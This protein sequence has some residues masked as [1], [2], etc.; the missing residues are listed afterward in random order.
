[1]CSNEQA[2]VRSD[3]VNRGVDMREELAAFEVDKPGPIKH[4]AVV[5]ERGPDMVPE[6]AAAEDAFGSFRHVEQDHESAA[7]DEYVVPI[8][9][10]DRPAQVDEA[11]PLEVQPPRAAVVKKIQLEISWRPY[12]RR[13]QVS[14]AA[15]VE[16]AAGRPG[17]IS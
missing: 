16:G 3:A 13:V 1:M 17:Q 7:Y 4:M 10:D 8:R 6:L 15:L 11:S 5:T 9:C 2:A 12:R 14:S